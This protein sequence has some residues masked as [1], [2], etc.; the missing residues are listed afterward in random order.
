MTLLYLASYLKQNGISSKV[1]DLGSE[2]EH[3]IK[4]IEKKI[5]EYQPKFVIIGIRWYF[6]L[7]V[8]IKIA[9]TVKNIEEDI[10]IIAGGQTAGYFDKEIIRNSK[11]DYI[12][13]GDAEKPL[14][15]LI[16]ERK[17]INTTY[18]KQERIIRTARRYIQTK[19]D[20]K[21]LCLTDEI[22]QILEKDT[23]V[24]KKTGHW[25]GEFIWTGKGCCYNCFYCSG[26]NRNQKRLSGREKPIFRDIP[27]V[28]KDIN[29]L[30]R[31]NDN[32]IFDFDPFQNDKKFYIKLFEKINMPELKSK[33]YAWTLPQKELLSAFKNSF[34]SSTLSLSVETC[35]EAFRKS[36][37]SKDITRPFFSN[38]QLEKMIKTLEINK[39][40]FHLYLIA[41][42]PW[43]DE[44]IF[45]YN[46]DYCL[47]L[48]KRNTSVF[49]KNISRNISCVPLS[50]EPGSDIYM[51]PGRYDMKLYRRNFF[52]FLELSKTSFNKNIPYPFR[53]DA[54]GTEIEHP[55][56]VSS[57][58][59]SE[60]EVHR[61]IVR[62]YQALREDE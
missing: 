26:C 13:R 48:L 43:E 19:D 39:Q 36:L 30:S 38:F 53:F 9:E 42:L 29:I 17:L 44:K 59:S 5:Y 49:Q 2:R 10:K 52:D 33:F 25:A 40:F 6:D 4:I 55:F 35:N 51:N 24:L 23:L 16:R 12:I 62:F 58:K 45:D 8:S 61:K 18:K 56:G 34:S 15:K 31:Y 3:F 47:N 1:I 41:G 21:G 57:I 60:N 54:I 50:A 27:S 7:Y 46:T 37:S 32:I 14:L 22:D 11:I 28:I 20:I